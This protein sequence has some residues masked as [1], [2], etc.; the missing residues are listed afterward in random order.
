VLVL[1]E[2]H[3]LRVGNKEQQ[4]E[5]SARIPGSHSQPLFLRILTAAE[6]RFEETRSLRVPFVLFAG[7]TK[8]AIQMLSLLDI[9]MKIALHNRDIR[10][11]FSVCLSFLVQWLS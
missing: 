8:G 1:L 6:V 11:H 5:W 7:R 3:G 10:E 4:G 2:L 9:R